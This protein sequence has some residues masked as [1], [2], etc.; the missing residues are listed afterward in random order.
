MY[1]YRGKLGLIIASSNGVFESEAPRLVASGVSCHFARAPYPSPGTDEGALAV[2]QSIE[3][4][5][6]LLAGAPGS[7]GVDAIC[8]NHG[9]ATLAKGLETDHYVREKIAKATGVM[10]TTSTTAIFEGLRKLGVKHVSLSVTFDSPQN[11]RMKEAF[12]ASGFEVEAMVPSGLVQPPPRLDHTVVSSQPPSTAYKLGKMADRPQSEAIVVSNSN[13]RT[14]EIIDSL[15]RDLAK[16]VVTANQ[17]SIWHCLRLIGIHE[18][19]R[20]FGRLLE[21]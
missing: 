15:E 10:A 9:P 20:G 14:I 2:L 4:C 7:L 1:G 5:A 11:Q 8:V 12:V 6:K 3:D 21:I 17:A 18:P 16:Y 13:L 19:V